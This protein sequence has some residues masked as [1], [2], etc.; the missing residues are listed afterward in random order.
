MSWW[1]DRPEKLSGDSYLAS[2]KSHSYSTHS[3]DATRRILPL[4]QSPPLPARPEGK[5]TWT[6]GLGIFYLVCQSVQ[7]LS[8]A[9]LFRGPMDCSMPGFPVHRP[10]LEPTQTRIHR[11]G[12]VIQPSHP[13]SSPSPAAFNLSQHQ[14]LFQCISPSHQVAKVLE[15]HL[16]H[17]FFQQIFRTDFL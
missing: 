17:Q 12:D 15:F 11:A 7:S 1:Q 9:Q 3:R 5:R 6:V 4:M 13:L 16:Q 10:L 14:S 2:N 8:H